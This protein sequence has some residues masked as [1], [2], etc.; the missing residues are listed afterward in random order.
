MASWGICLSDDSLAGHFTQGEL[1]SHKAQFDTL[2]SS[3]EPFITH[4]DLKNNY[5]KLGFEK[6][7]TDEDVV[8]IME[9]HDT[10]KTRRLSFE[11]FLR[12][13]LDLDKSNSYFS[14]MLSPRPSAT[15]REFVRTPSSISRHTINESEKKA[16]VDHIN[17]C[18]EDDVHLMRQIPID[19]LSSDFFDIVKEGVLLCKLINVA[20][21]N[22]I[23]IRA[24]NTK[25]KLNP[26]ER[27]EN[28]RLCLN[29]AQAIGC[30]VVNI[31][32]QDLSDGKAHLVLGLVAQI[33]KVQLLSKVNVKASPELAELMYDKEEFEELLKLSSEDMLLRWINHH[34][35]KAGVNR[36]VKNFTQD[37]K[38]GEV[39][40]HLLHH[41][42]P[43]SCS[44][45]PLEAAPG[46]ERAKQVLLQAEHL[47]CWK[48]LQ[49]KDILEG[50]P[51][52]NLAFV[53][54]LF[55]TRNGLEVD[56]SK[57][58]QAE[59]LLDDVEDEERVFRLWIN[60]VGT[61]TFVKNLIEDLRDG[62]VLLEVLDKLKPGCVNWR[63]ATKSPVKIS[64]KKL[65]NCNQVIEIGKALRFSLVGIAG[66][67]I[68]AGNKKLVLGLLWQLM[69]F[70]ILKLLQ[71][72]TQ[73]GQGDNGEITD[74]D[75]LQWANKKVKSAGKSTSIE[76]YKDKS[77]AS[78]L[79]FL[80]LLGAVEPQVVNWSL[81]TKGDSDDNK[82]QNATYIISVARKLGCSIFLSPDD[83]VEVRPKMILTLL[84]S[85]MYNALVAKRA[86]DAAIA[87]ALHADDHSAEQSPS[88][89]LPPSGPNQT[90]L[91]RSQMFIT[92]TRNTASLARSFLHAQSFNSRLQ[93]SP[94]TPSTAAS[95]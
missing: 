94:S 83:I 53:A 48:Y 47:G 79:F 24:I 22:T 11:G 4:N 8:K 67:D 86:K 63:Q 43:E 3:P 54:N 20:V 10:T 42:A 64:F 45:S 32:T 68:T 40:T 92:P 70:N 7:L 31:G 12:L 88:T 5:V 17:A 60:S 23:D 90:R 14:P 77:L 93:K 66:N 69:R 46:I 75:V 27:I 52:L 65:E 39:Y 29:S 38:D 72:L 81:V 30:S 62:V 15:K 78:G 51:N 73:L 50:S 82:L 9:D 16:Y 49:P 84:A 18:L 34:L 56:Q 74:S 57:V 26:W 95:P 85:I 91:D 58:Q 61:P 37:L 21:P 89:P 19:P 41:L 33:V 55:Q 13:Q 6:P 76:S 71:D 2:H 1:R 80:D 25:E 28:H 35:K 44:L 36:V 87:T 59:L